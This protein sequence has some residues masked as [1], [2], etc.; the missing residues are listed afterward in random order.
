MEDRIEILK[1]FIIE[2]PN[3]PFNHYALGLEYLQRDEVKAADIF[4]RLLQQHGDYI[5]V[6]YQLAKLYAGMGSIERAVQ[7]FNEGIKA[8]EAA[9]DFKTLRELRAGLEELED[10]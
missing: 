3:D 6:Y 2:D 10:L 9:K 7:I 4:E 5:P 1:Q 8:A